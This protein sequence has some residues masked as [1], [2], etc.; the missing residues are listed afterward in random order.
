MSEPIATHSRID[1]HLVRDRLV[2]QLKNVDAA[3][4]KALVGLGIQTVGDLLWHV[5]FR[6][7]DMTTVIPISSVFDGDATVVGHV[8]EVLVKKPRPK[9]TVTEVVINDGSGA[10]VGVWFN[11][12]WIQR[13]FEVGQRCAF[14][15]AV[16]F[17][18]GMRRMANPYVE[19]L[20]EA[21]A[22]H[23]AMVPVYR[24]TE[25]LAQG[26]LRKIISEAVI[27][28]SWGLDEIPLNVRN[29]LQ[30]PS[31]SWAFLRIHKP[32]SLA[33]TQI[34]RRR[35][36]F[37]E[38]FWLQLVF[39]YKRSLRLREAHGISHVTTGPMLE[40][41]REV[42]GFYP[43]E[44]QT[45][46]I[47]Q[48]LE[49]MAAPYSMQRMVLGD[50]GTGKTMVAAHALFAVADTGTQ[51]V[52]MAPT[53]VLA[54]QYARKVGPVLDTCD[55][56][57]AVLTGS[58]SQAEKQS[59]KARLAEGAIT[60]LFGTHAVIQEDVE[61]KSLSLV[62]IDEQHRFGVQQ[63]KQLRSKAADPDVLVM[64]ATP[65]PRS[66]TLVA[67]G[68]LDV[69]TLHHRPIEGAG[70]TTKVLK[71]SQ[72]YKAHEAVHQAVKQGRQAYIICALVEDS[73]ALAVQ[74]ATRQAEM[75]SA[76]EYAQLRVGLLTGRMS[77]KEKQVVM[78]QF[79][80]G[81]IDVLVA[82]TVIEVGVDVPNATQMIVLDAERF[83]LAQLHQLRGRV[84]RGAYSGEVWL[85]SDT[86]N[87]ETQ[88]RLAALESTS[89]GF[90]VAQLD[91]ELRGAG[92]VMGT[93]QHGSAALK[94][95][96]LALDSDLLSQAYDSAEALI[97]EDPTL[98]KG[99][100]A[101]AKH[102]LLDLLRSYDEWVKA[103]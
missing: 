26:W 63:R 76:G 52:M 14:T 5:P 57:W 16:K 42:F 64:S 43:S 1:R 56:S 31:L 35:L 66:L 6:Y 94:V 71:P 24:T 69:S 9:L 17:E 3:R 99:I 93:R 21:N 92:D 60:V 70:V 45:V 101:L 84:G 80:A 95:A 4:A 46:A 13:T 79:V 38:L 48:I 41:G 54:Q 59:I 34:A 37:E 23:A 47:A 29:E 30:L 86:P 96:D 53:E 44:E 58:T 100:Y 72:S 20:S 40:L 91:L 15:G 88:K 11:Q 28:G 61:F 68:D 2:S 36:A 27:Q 82:T 33:D 51:A 19:Q 65:I 77:S 8:V 25:K 22:H 83:G 90:A 98:S 87:P 81:D 12:P 50:V 18:F 102:R 74:S 7:L 89:D 49:D 78:Q 73:D 85:I 32:Q 97:A 67:Y 55:I 62:I 10:L 75:L 103:G 39:A